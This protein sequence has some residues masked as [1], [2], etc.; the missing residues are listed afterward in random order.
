MHE[1]KKDITLFSGISQLATTLL[2][3]GLFMVPAIAAG[4]TG[5]LTLWAWCI[6]FIAICPIALTFATLGKHYPNAGGTA[7]FVRMAFSKRLENAV[8]WLFM[9]I[10]PVGIPPAIA[11]AGGF[12]KPILPHFLANDWCAQ[13]LTVA[14]LLLVNLMGSKSSGQ[15]QSLIA[16]CIFALIG[17]FFWQGHIGVNDLVMPALHIHDAVPIGQALAVMF[18]CFVGIEAFAHMGEEF[19]NPQRDFPIAILAGC[20]IAGLVY[21]ACTVVILKFNAYGS[22]HFDNG[23]IPWLSDHLFGSSMALVISV[24]GFFACFASINLYTQSL[25]RMVLSQARQYRPSSALVSVSSRGVSVRA[26]YV[27]FSVITASCVLGLVTNLDL[28]FFLKLANSV[29]VMIYLLAML[30]AT[31]L[32]QGKARYLAYVSLLLCLLAFLCLGWS[33][34]YAVIILMVFMRPW[35]R[36]A[37]R[38]Y[39]NQ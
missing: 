25:S 33:M 15:L 19:K 18:W 23:S 38:Q 39:V 14:L 11:L 22:S 1:L 24:I 35:Q 32:L 2:G 36:H 26:T 21:W 34:L 28:S 9:S 29:F 6:L 16:L 4:I 5:S 27:V 30:A 12:L 8:A 3:T 13:L 31:R 20:F 37:P 17:G 10:M 7:Y